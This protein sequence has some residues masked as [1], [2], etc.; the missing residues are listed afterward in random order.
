MNLISYACRKQRCVSTIRKK[1]F[2][3]PQNNIIHLAERGGRGRDKERG[4]IGWGKEKEE[5]E[6]REREG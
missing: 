4:E 5:E 1:L 6:Q 2:R 3:V